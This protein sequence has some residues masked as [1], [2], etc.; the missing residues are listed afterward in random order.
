MAGF[1]IRPMGDRA[2]VAEFGASIDEATN[3]QVHALAAWIGARR[4]PGIVE[5]APTYRSLLVCYDPAVISFA[6]LKRRLERFHPDVVAA[7]AARRRILKVPC[8]YGGAFGPDLAGMEEITGLSA[9][10]IVRIHSA[11]DYRIYM[12]GF[13]PGFPYLGGLDKRIEASR[14]PSPR[15]A[16]PAGSVGIGGNQTGVYPM[17]SPGGWRLMGERRFLSMILR[18]RGRFCAKQGNSSALCPFPPKN[19]RISSA[20]LPKAAIR[21]ST[22]RKKEAKTHAADHPLPRALDYRTG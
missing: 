21:L 7:T 3:R 17:E 12:L 4:V 10:E 22:L 19:S 9:Q 13:L 14:L 18:R 11:V 20:A 15:K 2:L 8:C 1:T 6:R 5:L 16:I